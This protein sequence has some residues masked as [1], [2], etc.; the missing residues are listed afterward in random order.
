MIFSVF[1]ICNSRGENIKMSFCFF[2]SIFVGIFL[3]EQIL[4]NKSVVNM[5]GLLFIIHY[6]IFLFFY[7]ILYFMFF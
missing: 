5:I 2:I 4:I 1:G 6:L 7:N 3:H